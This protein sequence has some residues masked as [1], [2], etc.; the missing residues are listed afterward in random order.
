MHCYM[1]GRCSNPEQPLGYL[2]KIKVNSTYK[3]QKKS[4]IT[5]FLSYGFDLVQ[6]K[7]I[8]IRILFDF[9]SSR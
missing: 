1:Q 4:R 2:K 6:T 5:F 8:H 7:F 9:N 3:Y